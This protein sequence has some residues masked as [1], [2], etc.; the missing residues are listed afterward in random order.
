MSAWDASR[1]GTASIHDLAAIVDFSTAERR[2]T[3]R[4][5]AAHRY[6]C[7]GRSVVSSR[8]RETRL[9][10]AGSGT[11]S[12]V[13]APPGVRLARGPPAVIEPSSGAASDVTEPSNG[14]GILT[15]R[16][17]TTLATH[18]RL[19]TAVTH[20]SSDER[21]ASFAIMY[22]FRHHGPRRVGGS[23]AREPLTVAGNEGPRAF[24]LPSSGRGGSF[25]TVMLAGAT[26]ET[27]TTWST[28]RYY[29]SWA[30]GST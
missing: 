30:I 20:I 22:P 18:E 10:A 26:P 15:A 8:R 28:P 7:S 13:H 17:P 23:H 16:A 1:G 2:R 4:P 25:R 27:R 11:G 5:G 14:T 21:T 3:A 29:P 24:R 12:S 9:Q 19:T 6:A